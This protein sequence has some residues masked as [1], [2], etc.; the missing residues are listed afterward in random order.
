M[1]STIRSVVLPI[2][3]VLTMAAGAYLIKT[4]ENDAAIDTVASDES[5]NIDKKVAQLEPES[6]VEADGAVTDSAV[7]DSAE[8]ANNKADDEGTVDTNA[9][10]VELVSGNDVTSTEVDAGLVSDVSEGSDGDLVTE[11]EAPH[12]HKTDEVMALLEERLPHIPL[13]GVSESIIPQLYEIITEGQVYYVDETAEFLVD[14]NLIRLSDGTNLTDTTLGRIHTGFI[15]EIDE[16]DMLIYEPE[17]ASD[18]S[19]TI[20][21]DISCGFCRRLHEEIDTLLEGGVRVRYLMFPRAGLGTQSHAD[22]E[23]VWCADNPQDAMTH[24]KAGGAIEPKT[25]DNPIESHMELATKVGLR[26]TP[27]I[28]LDSGVK[29]PGYREAVELTRMVNTSEPLTN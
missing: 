16:K 9:E 20:F 5:V 8:L 3:L 13:T 14:G 4:G 10:T 11:P 27:L 2:G 15:D 7:T 6:S 18:R 29:V 19:I 26:G 25:C 12:L 17:E 1:L 24:A 22:L 23:S 28:Y 21:T